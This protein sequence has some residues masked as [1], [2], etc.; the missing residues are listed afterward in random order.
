[1]Q[2]LKRVVCI[3]LSKSI[4]TLIVNTVNKICGNT[5][6]LIKKYAV[7][8][9]IYSIFLL[10]LLFVMV[11]LNMNGTRPKIALFFTVFFVTSIII[12]LLTFNFVLK[13]GEGYEQKQKAELIEMQ[14][15]MLKK[16]LNETESAFELWRK[17]VHDYKNNIIALTQLAE[18]GDIEKI[19]KYLQNEKNLIN[20]K[21]FYI[22]TGNSVVDA[23]VNT[24]QNFAENQGITFVVNAAIPKE[25]RIND[26]D[27]ANILGNVI[28]NAL[29]ASSRE[30]NAYIDLT[31]RQEKNFIVIKIVNKYSRELP[32]EMKSTKNDKVFHGIGIRSVRD[33][34]QKYN[35]EFSIIKK[36]DEVIV[37]ILLLNKK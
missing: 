37:Q 3:L 16:S 18:D 36:N 30:S 9:C 23:I 31:I 12:E 8:M 32:N 28:D 14:N 13:M 1:M 19:K 15:S 11:E 20:R 25:C 6:V 35:G 22:R 17:S 4:L 7:I 24:K 21:M 29:E 26:I 34:V 2:S 27:F 33:I 10:G 5:I